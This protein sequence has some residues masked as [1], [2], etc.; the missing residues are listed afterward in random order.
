MP[1]GKYHLETLLYKA[2][3]EGTMPN[4]R[5]KF[6]HNG[7]LHLMLVPGACRVTLQRRARFEGEDTIG[8][9][10]AWL[11]NLYSRLKDGEQAHSYLVKLLKNPFINL[12]NAYRHPK[13]TLY[14]TTL[15]ANFGATAGIAELLL[16][17]HDGCI[18]LLPALPQAW[19]SGQ[20]KGLRARGGFE[21][22]LFWN[23]GRLTRATIRSI[24][25]GECRIHYTVPVK[26][27]DHIKSVQEE[28][29]ED[30]LA[31]TVQAGESYEI[32]PI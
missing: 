16:Q 5:K 2:Q 15:E 23:E 20:I 1:T 7:Q 11:I 26:L 9:C 27:S 12:L 6:R 19:P 30:I 10:F 25:D 8:W 14:P 4:T 18:D 29:S 22:D 28:K 32:V 3:E 17:S 24:V 13:L 21:V 31:F